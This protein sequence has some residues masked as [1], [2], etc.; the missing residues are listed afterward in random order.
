MINLSAQLAGSID[1][2]NYY[3]VIP[4]AIGVVKIDSSFAACVGVYVRVPVN[5][6]AGVGLGVISRM[7]VMW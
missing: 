2:F 1:T 4:R 5:G 3:A 7:V 6:G